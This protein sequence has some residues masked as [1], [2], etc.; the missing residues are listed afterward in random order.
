MIRIAL[1]LILAAAIGLSPAAAGEKILV[2][3]QNNH[4]A[5]L[6]DLVTLKSL[7]VTKVGTQPLTAVVTHDRRYGL[8]TAVGFTTN[9]GDVTVLDINTQGMPLV[10]TVSKNARCYGVATTP[11]S[12]L[13]IVTRVAGST[14]EFQ[15][16]DLTATPPVDLGK[17][18]AIPNGRSAYGAEVSPDGKTA[19]LL[20]FS[21]ATLTVLDL[22]QSP[23]AVIKQ[24]GTNRS[25]IFMRLSNDGRRLV[26]S[27][28][29]TPAQ[30]G[31]WNTEGA[32]P[33]K[34]SNVQI[35]SNPGAI[36][37]FEPGNGFAVF[38]AASGRSVH[39]VDAH[40][41]PPAALGSVGS[42][43]SDL[44]GVTAT[45][46]GLSAWAAARSSNLL[47]E[48]DLRNPAAP[49]L[50]NRSLTVARGPNSVV[51]FGEVHAHGIPAVG[52]TYP[53]FISSPKDAGKAYILAA[54]FST[55][56]GIPIG[57]RTV[58]LHLDDLFAISQTIPGIFQ[59]FRG[60][61]NASGQAV[62]LLKIPP[63]PALSGFGFYLAA[64]VVD[65][66]APQGIGT[67]SNAEHVVLQ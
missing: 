55:R 61:L 6:I 12:K 27:S 36:P 57:S 7:A 59:N 51:A 37:S 34:I 47:V 29:T 24:L 10:A 32:L 38:A 16:V 58:P 21:G 52:S 5:E 13:A 64:V 60:F 63:S 31:I 33:V 43:G 42:V 28:I 41:T 56:P 65:S 3:N 4:S 17:P 15:L 67:I 44:R 40:S 2:S 22:T 50:T 46:D 53:V 54:S 8:V 26:V 30:A 11:D 1:F 45:T 18:V 14:P 66:A 49:V 23:P 48:V 25:A 19:Y 62:A 35:G 9:A 20:D 39:V